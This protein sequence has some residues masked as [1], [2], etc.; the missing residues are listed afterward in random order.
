[1]SVNRR[2]K[3]TEAL[4]QSLGH[5]FADRTLLEQALTHA[6]AVAGSRNPADNERLEFLGDRVLGLVIAEVLAERHPGASAGEL[7][8]RL[9]GLV[10][11]EACAEV[12]RSV[13]VGE[14][15]RLPPGETKRGARGQ[16][17]I[18][19]DACEAIIAALYFEL[20]LPGAAAIVRRLW[21]R[22]LDAPHDPAEANPKSALQEWA[23]ARGLPP[24]IYREVARSGPPHQPQFTLEVGI[25]H[26][27]AEV[28]TGGS[29]R[30]AEKVAALALLRRVRGGA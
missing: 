7:S 4:E 16:R 23:A 29:V 12:A 21:A 10:S 6:S 9:P 13:G 1:M 27:G 8:K 15:L 2:L 11:G 18:L 20:G 30:E 3:A 14:A 24:P 25:E 5:V 26:V 28:A 17:A 19:A 22:L